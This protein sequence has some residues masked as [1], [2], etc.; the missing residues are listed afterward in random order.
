MAK[1]EPGR[2]LSKVAKFVRNPLKDWSELD[3]QDSAAP[4]NG[5]SREMLKEMIERRQRNDFVRRREFDMLRKLRRRDAAGGRDDGGT[6]SQF[7]VSSTSGKTEGRALTLKKIDEIEEQMSQQWW[8]SRGP[9]SDGAAALPVPGSGP[10]V[11]ADMAGEHV[12][13]YADTVPGVTPHDSA[14]GDSASAGRSSDGDASHA[15]RQVYESG[16][17][18][19]AIRFA[20]SD[21]TGAEAI[22]LQTLAP[23]SAQAEHNHSWL[24]LLDLYRATGDSEKFVAANTRYAQRFKRQGPEWVSLRSLARDLQVAASVAQNSA[25]ADRPLG[26][27][28]WFAPAVLTRPSLGELTRAL[29]AATGPK[30]TLDWRALRNIDEEA[31]APLKALLAHWADSAVQIQFVGMGHLTA[32]LEQATPSNERTVDA[33]WWQLRMEAL[34][35]MHAAD[36]FELVALNYCIT[37]EVSPPPWIDPKGEFA[38]I[39]VVTE[40]PKPQRPAAPSLTLAS[41]SDEVPVDIGP[42]LPSLI[43]ELTGE[44]AAVWQRLDAELA[45]AVAPTISCAALVRI[46]FAAAGTL[47]NWVTARDERGQRVQFVD[48]HRLVTAFFGVIGIA[49]HAAVSPRQH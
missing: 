4:D 44:S 20:Q 38:S 23:D 2:L 1:E 14:Q 41:L 21:D 19:A 27:A 49:D 33:I 32:V 15:G 8:K 12:R 48:A 13:A 18:E 28:D 45:D 47:L 25:D 16:I 29:A 5:Y 26:V 40:A 6:P 7:N 11:P 24:A 9:A 22:L 42:K 17:E 35:V 31:A 43:G 39:E 36:D 10:E 37:Y 46:D 30:W 3:A 34:R